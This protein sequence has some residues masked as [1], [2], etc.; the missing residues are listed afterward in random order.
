MGELMGT[1]ED[2]RSRRPRV[3]LVPIRDPWDNKPPLGGPSQKL[4]VA[5]A[6]RNL[7]HESRR[8]VFHHVL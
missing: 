3:L 7:G 4:A 1:N 2:R 6:F 5:E 8:V